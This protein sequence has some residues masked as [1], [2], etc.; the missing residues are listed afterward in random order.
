[1]RR[2]GARCQYQA[3]HQARLGVG[4]MVGEIDVL[5]CALL[6]VLVVLVVSGVVLHSHAVRQR[7]NA[8]GA[9]AVPCRAVPNSSV[10]STLR[11]S[12]L[13]AKKYI[14]ARARARSR[15]FSRFRLMS[16]KLLN[17]NVLYS[18]VRT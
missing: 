12:A 7:G 13:L 14:S 3:Q 11:Q 10:P 17:F 2:E 15:R 9:H 5:W 8:N 4:L 18:L 16:L 6:D 1:M